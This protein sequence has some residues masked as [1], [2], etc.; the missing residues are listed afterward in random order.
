MFRPPL[1]LRDQRVLGSSGDR[2]RFR[3]RRGLD[4]PKA[5]LSACGPSLRFAASPHPSAFEAG[6]KSATR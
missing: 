6:R 2:D 3:N 1:A 4:L 5:N